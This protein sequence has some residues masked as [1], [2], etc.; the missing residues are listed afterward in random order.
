MKK[1][2]F[3]AF[4]AMFAISA[5]E[6]RV[7][8]LPAGV[9]SAA[10]ATFNYV[11]TKLVNSLPN[12][13]VIR[14][15]DSKEILKSAEADGF[16]VEPYVG[17][18]VAEKIV[19]PM[20]GVNFRYD[21]KYLDYR[22]GGYIIDRKQNKESLNAGNH[23]LSYGATAAMNVHLL[24]R[25]AHTDAISLFGEVGY[26]YGKHKKL[27]DEEPAEDREG[28]YLKTV[29]HTG[30]GVTYG[31]GLEWRHNFFTAGNSLNIRLGFRALPNTFWNNTNLD[32]EAFLQIG[33]TFGIA[34][35]RFVNPNW[36][37]VK[38]SRR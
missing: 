4:A 27:V 11:G 8:N 19:S 7:N 9:D 31:G 26:L 20:G 33:F 10:L 13:H 23:Y 28:T 24:Y 14:Y 1:M 32:G 21:G 34:R 22:L 17:V 37:T 38:S 5:Q 18:T 15:E 3:A 2:I 35:H 29:K 12:T 16:G 36:K 25:G 6:A 30:S